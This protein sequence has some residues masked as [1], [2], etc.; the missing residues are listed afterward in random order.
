[1]TQFGGEFTDISPGRVGLS[2][3]GPRAH[4]RLALQ[5]KQVLIDVDNAENNL[6]DWIAYHDVNLANSLRR[7]S[8]SQ[9]ANDIRTSPLAKVLVA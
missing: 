9:T 3:C 5:L 7:P 4:Q 2:N 1:M 6:L 8:A